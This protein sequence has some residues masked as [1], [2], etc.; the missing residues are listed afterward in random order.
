MVGRLKRLNQLKWWQ[1]ILLVA[2]FPL[3]LIALG[4]DY[5]ADV[6]DAVDE[7]MRGPRGY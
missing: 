4:L 3:W 1:K 2:V 5:I 6:M 7:T